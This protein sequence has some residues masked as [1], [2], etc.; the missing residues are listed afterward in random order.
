MR[1]NLLERRSKMLKLS[2]MGF[3]LVEIV[4]SLSDEYKVLGRLST[5][6]GISARHGW[7]R[8]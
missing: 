7:N 1:A 5:M 2:G 4:K 3:S 6:I 8:F